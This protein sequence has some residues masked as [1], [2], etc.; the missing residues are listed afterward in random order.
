MLT[1]Y[2]FV[3]RDILEISNVGQLKV[4]LPAA[5]SATTFFSGGFTLQVFNKDVDNMLI[6]GRSHSCRLE[7]DGEIDSLFLHSS[8]EQFK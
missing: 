7:L 2:E 3:G 1:D 6:I 8:P 4:R 5:C